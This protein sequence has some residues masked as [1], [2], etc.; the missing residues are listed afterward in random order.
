MSISI[1]DTQCGAKLFRVTDNLALAL[2]E[3]FDSR[4]IFDVELIARLQLQ[5]DKEVNAAM[6]D[7]KLSNRVLPLPLSETIYE[8]PLDSW[9]DISG[10]KLSM[11]HKVQAL[12]GLIQIWLRYSTTSPWQDWP[13][14]KKVKSFSQKSFSQMYREDAL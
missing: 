9:R 12:Y 13:P 10:S 1:Y 11:K 3:P 6:P 14:Q 5:R 7:R 4:W 8:S 2:S